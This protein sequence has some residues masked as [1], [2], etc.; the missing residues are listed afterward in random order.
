MGKGELK[1]A[2]LGDLI[3]QKVRVERVVGVVAVL[4]VLRRLPRQADE[5]EGAEV[6][7]SESKGSLD[8]GG[9]EAGLAAKSAK[10]IGDG[11]A[12]LV[13]LA[14]AKSSKG[15][16]SPRVISDTENDLTDRAL[17]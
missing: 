13:C 9:R 17:H 1:I 4:E 15:H 7:Q 10:D 3:P 14:A 6:I 8:S 12:L 5:D 11:D 16:L 2:L